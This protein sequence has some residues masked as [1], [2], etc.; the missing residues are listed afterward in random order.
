MF[1]L[2]RGGNFFNFFISLLLFYLV[3]YNFV[4]EIVFILLTNFNEMLFYSY[5][6]I[7]LG[8]VYTMLLFFYPGSYASYIISVAGCF[9]FFL[10]GLLV[11]G[12]F[13]GIYNSSVNNYLNLFEISCCY[14]FLSSG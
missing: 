10:I 4:S 8:F 2:F 11:L 14:I 3:L 12:P 9:L 7:I 13:Q 6:L 1:S 5:S